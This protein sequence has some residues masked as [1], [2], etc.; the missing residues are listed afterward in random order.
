MKERETELKTQEQNLTAK[1]S[2]IES[3]L[4]G[5]KKEIEQLKASEKSNL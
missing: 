1:L 2:S 4:T 3:L 5:Y